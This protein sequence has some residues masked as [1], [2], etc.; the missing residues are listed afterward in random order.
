MGVH[1]DYLGNEM[2]KSIQ[3]RYPFTS[4]LLLLVFGLVNF[5]FDPVPKI[6]FPWE[7]F[8]YM[9]Y[10]CLLLFAGLCVLLLRQYVDMRLNPGRFRQNSFDLTVK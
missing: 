9:G 5:V 1:T 2:K 8:L 6:G 7:G 3:A 4:C 10:I